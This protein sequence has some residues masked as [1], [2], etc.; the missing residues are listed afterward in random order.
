MS[1]YALY[2]KIR[3]MLGNPSEDEIS[4]EDIS[5]F[6]SQA[7]LEYAY[8]NPRTSSITLVSSTNYD[9][10]SLDANILDIQGL[11]QTNNAQT[12]IA[13]TYDTTAQEIVVTDDNSGAATVNYIISY[14]YT[15]VPSIDRIFVEYL[16]V[17]FCFDQIAAIR[18]RLPILSNF[19]LVSGRD[20]YNES[21]RYMAKWRT[22]FEHSEVL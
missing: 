17:S 12:A 21:N 20:I 7:L 16:C 9:A 18:D 11:Y 4:T 2:Q 22:R 1:D 19:R 14:E 8:V 3:R 15:D 5:T 10:T 13:Y 6:F